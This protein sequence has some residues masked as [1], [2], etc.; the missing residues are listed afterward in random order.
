VTCGANP[1]RLFPR[2][3]KL[4]DVAAD[5]A[6]A[7]DDSGPAGFALVSVISSQ[8]DAGTGGGDRAGDVE[9]W[10]VGTDDTHGRLRAALS[11]HATRVY[12]LT[13][14]G[15]DR[16]GNVATCTATVSVPRRRAAS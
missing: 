3:R 5:V 14:R 15:F 9:G 12:T 8:P 16:A 11:D 10:A 13:Y 7:D 4:V 6:V 1:A 2:N